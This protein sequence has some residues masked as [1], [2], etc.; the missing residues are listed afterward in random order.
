MSKQNR[1]VYSTETGR[2]CPNCDCAITHC[3]CKKQKTQIKN[4]DGFIRIAR[5]TKGRKGAGVSLITGL[6]LDA[7]ELKDTAKKIKQLC[8]SGGAIKDGI[9]E[10]QGDH[11]DKIEEWLNGQGYKTKRVGG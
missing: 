5:E 1:R 11:R 2:I 8:S 3:K 7:S 6:P 4:N 9:I 10:I